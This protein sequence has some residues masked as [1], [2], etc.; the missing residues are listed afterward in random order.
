MTILH[1]NPPVIHIPGTYEADL[2]P[3]AD[4]SKRYAELIPGLSEAD[5]GRLY[6]LGN[7]A[8]RITAQIHLPW[9]LDLAH[10]DP[11]SAWN[12]LQVERRSDAATLTPGRRMALETAKILADSRIAHRIHERPG[13]IGG[14]VLSNELAEQVEADPAF[15]ERR[16]AWNAAPNS[17]PAFTAM[18]S[19]LLTVVAYALPPIGRSAL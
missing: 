4:I 8:S 9:A 10:A 18:K 14:A 6:Q 5:Y 3:G 11:R 7:L 2:I 13:L 19:R 15:C 1:N 12:I 17:D 16:R